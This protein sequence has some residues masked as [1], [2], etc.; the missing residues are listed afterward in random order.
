M[1]FLRAFF[2][3]LY[4]TLIAMVR[5][6]QIVGLNVLFGENMPRTLRIRRS[7]ARH[8]LPAL[9]VQSSVEGNPPDF[10]CILMGNHRSYLDPFVL[11]CDVYGLVVA[12]SELSSWPIFGYGAK[13]T[14]VLFLKRENP[15]SRKFTLNRIAQKVAEGFPVFLYP[16]GTTGALDQTLDFRIGGFIL[17][18]SNNIPIVPVAIEYGSKDDYWVG[19]D[20][21]VAHFFRRF[22]EKKMRVAVRF[23][24]PILGSDAT[25]LSAQCKSWLDAQLPEMQESLKRSAEI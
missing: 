17:A 2:R 10:P 1:K 3:L 4:F 25:L 18:A 16:E 19:D 5:I 24:F 23:G 12:K 22:S 9:G 20:T 6:V 11:V 21:F 15:Q 14:G 13:I 7:W 8:W